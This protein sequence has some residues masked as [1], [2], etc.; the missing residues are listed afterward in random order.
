MAEFYEVELRV[1]YQETDQMA[2][3]YHANYLNWFEVGRTEWLRE[4]GLSYRSMEEQGWLLPVTEVWC[5]YHASAKYDDLVRIKI[6]IDTLSKLRMTFGY[7]VTRATDGE[8]LVSGKTEHVFINREGQ[9]QRIN[10]ILPD[11][12]ELMQQ[13]AV[14]SR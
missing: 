1:R 11:L 8:K 7:E 13:K 14:S 5:K 3:V 12:Y 4:Y 9:V 10:R 6:W 2:I